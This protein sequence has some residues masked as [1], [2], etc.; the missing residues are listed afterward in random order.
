MDAAALGLENTTASESRICDTDMAKMM[1]EYSNQ[2]ILLQAGQA[3]LA[4]ANH[5]QDGGL[6]LLRG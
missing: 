1:V 5:Q 4:Q 2:N 3:V 6:T